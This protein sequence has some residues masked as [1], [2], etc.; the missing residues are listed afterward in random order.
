[1]KLKVLRE[2]YNNAWSKNWGF[3]PMTDDEFDH[4]AADMKQVADPDFIFIVEKD[5][6]A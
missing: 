2:V 4:L 1:M 5:G 3:V 6:K